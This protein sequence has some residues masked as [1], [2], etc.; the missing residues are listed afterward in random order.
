MI[1][2]QRDGHS[3]STDTAAV[4]RLDEPR[5]AYSVALS[6]KFMLSPP[7]PGLCIKAVVGPDLDH[8]DLKDGTIC[9][10]R[11]DADGNCHPET[12]ACGHLK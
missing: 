12:L 4:R 8:I 3:A 9:V 10:A 5:K 7:V 6:D 11:R 1:T 2:A